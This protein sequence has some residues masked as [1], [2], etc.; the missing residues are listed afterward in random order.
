MSN[1]LIYSVLILLTLSIILSLLGLKKD[2]NKLP[3]SV[4]Y[5]MDNYEDFLKESNY[6][7]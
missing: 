4:T 1:K 5:L 6:E 3:E 2:E 7:P